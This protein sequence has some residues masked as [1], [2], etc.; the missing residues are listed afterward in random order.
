MANSLNH[1]I[2][3]SGED[4]LLKKYEYPDQPWANIEFKKPPNAPLQELSN[5]SIGTVCWDVSREFKMFATG[6]KD[7]MVLL[8]PLSNF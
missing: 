6:G 8:R 1:D 5:H 4:K 3:V 7:G 2:Y